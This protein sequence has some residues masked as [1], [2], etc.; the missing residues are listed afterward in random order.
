[1]GEPTSL[2]VFK[3]SIDQH[4]GRTSFAR[5]LSGTIKADSSMLNASTG[6]PERLGK[7]V[8]VVGKETKQVDEAKAGDIV[9]LAKLKATLSGQTLSDEKHP[10]LYSAPDLPPPLFSRGVKFEGKG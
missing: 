3:T 9:A 5:I 2:F 8:N 6:N 4:A 10:F 7:I 1:E